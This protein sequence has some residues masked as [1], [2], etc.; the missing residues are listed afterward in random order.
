MR[1]GVPNYITRTYT[2]PLYLLQGLAGL[3]LLLCCTNVGGLMLTRVYS[4]QREFAVRTALGAPVWRI[5]RQY[6]SEA[7][8]IAAAGSI[9][10]A[11]LARYGSSFFLPFFRDPMMGEPMQV[12]P[13]RAVF[14]AAAGLAVLTTFFFGL[15][16]HGALDMPIPASC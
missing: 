16:P 5:V 9:L 13:N 11:I 4:R 10:G 3:V 7:F 15:L 12:G 14:F 2:K 6:I 1:S 8:L